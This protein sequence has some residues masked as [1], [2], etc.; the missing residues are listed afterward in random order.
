MQ[1]TA[2][3]SYIPSFPSFPSPVTTG[4]MSL[5]PLLHHLLLF[6]YILVIA[7]QIVSLSNAPQIFQLDYVSYF[8][9]G[10]KLIQAR[11]VF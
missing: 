1:S 11:K 3:F 5:A 6:L 8:L 2:T 9:L 10:P 7:L 4:L